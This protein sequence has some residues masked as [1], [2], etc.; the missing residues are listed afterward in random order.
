MSSSRRQRL[1][2]CHSLDDSDYNKGLIDGIFSVWSCSL[3]RRTGD[4]SG[5]GGLLGGA[6]RRGLA[7]GRQGRIVARATCAAGMARTKVELAGVPRRTGG[8]VRET[9]G[10]FGLVAPGGTRGDAGTDAAAGD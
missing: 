1:G 4:G 8:A 3:A 7:I 10:A 6:R 5:A 2:D 9:A